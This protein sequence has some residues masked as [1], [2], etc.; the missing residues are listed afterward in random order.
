MHRVTTKALGHMK[1]LLIRKHSSCD[2]NDWNHIRA[3]F[4]HERAVNH[5]CVLK[6]T[7]VFKKYN[8]K[9]PSETWTAA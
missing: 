1:D 3:N 6:R 7:R 5:S 2:P 8:L 9:N 4:I